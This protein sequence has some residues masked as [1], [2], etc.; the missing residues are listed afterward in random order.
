MLSG[1]C[2]FCVVHVLVVVAV[3]AKWPA[4]KSRYKLKEN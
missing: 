2:C 4:N 3:V 1:V